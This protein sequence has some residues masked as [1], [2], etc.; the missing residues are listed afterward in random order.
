MSGK[1]VVNRS[2]SLDGFIA[3]P[4][5]AMDWVFDFVGRRTAMSRCATT[6]NQAAAGSA[7]G[8]VMVTPE[9]NHSTSGVLKNAVDY[10]APLRAASRAAA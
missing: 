7:H 4:G 3:G 10:L 5:D 1:V 2:M 9:Y 8:F 6:R